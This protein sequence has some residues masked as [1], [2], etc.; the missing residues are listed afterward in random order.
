MEVRNKRRKRKVTKKKKRKSTKENLKTMLK[1]GRW[2]EEENA[3][4]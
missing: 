4:F 2:D 3:R 1:R